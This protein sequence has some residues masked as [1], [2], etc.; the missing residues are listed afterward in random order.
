MARNGLIAQFAEFLT[1]SGTQKK[2]LKKKA[3]DNNEMLNNRWTLAILWL[4]DKKFAGI[5]FVC[6]FQGVIKIPGKWPHMGTPLYICTCI[7]P[8]LTLSR[9]RSR[10]C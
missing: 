5:C 10:H 6:R 1:L 3:G 9:C 8:F 2:N 7:C 4:T